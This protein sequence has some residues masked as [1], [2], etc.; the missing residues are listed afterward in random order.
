MRKILFVTF[1]L[2]MAPSLYASWWPS[3]S[4]RLV[5]MF[6]G[7]T[8]TVQVEARWSGL[9]DYGNGVHWAFRSEHEGVASAYVEMS[10]ARRR[11]VEIVALAP[12]RTSIREQ[13]P[14]G[15][16]GSVE[17]VVIE[18]LC[19]AEDPV[20]PEFPARAATIGKPVA[21]HVITDHADRTAFAWYLGRAGDRTHPLLAGGASIDFIP[22]AAGTLYVWV[23]AITGCST[24]NAEFRIDVEPARNRAVRH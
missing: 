4:T 12:G 23:E 17:W 9:V 6:V 16:L 18:V 19:R 22:T 21:L 1:A 13:Y 5:S 10:D 15:H 24:S 2:L 20:R 3:W 11:D 7:D 14:N 8:A